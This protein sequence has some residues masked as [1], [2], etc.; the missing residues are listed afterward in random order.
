MQL[1][2]YSYLRYQNVS[3]FSLVGLAKMMTPMNKSQCAWIAALV[4]QILLLPIFPSKLLPGDRHSF[5][6]NQ[7]ISVIWSYNFI[8]SL[9]D[10]KT[11]EDKIREEVLLSAILEFVQRR[12][13]IVDRMDEERIRYYMHHFLLSLANYYLLRHPW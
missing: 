5:R 9:E 6:L 4:I 7:L 12:S 8:S 10:E 2:S 3:L 1:V 13:E 11:E